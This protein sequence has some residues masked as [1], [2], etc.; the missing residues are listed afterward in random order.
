MVPTEPL[1]EK[2]IVQLLAPNE[3]RIASERDI[4]TLSNPQEINV[5]FAELSSTRY[6]TDY[7]GRRSEY[8][9]IY[10]ALKAAKKGINLVGLF[11][12]VRKMSLNEVIPGALTDM[13]KDF[14]SYRNS[15]IYFLDSNSFSPVYSY[16]KEHPV[17]P[18]SRG[19]YDLGIENRPKSK[20]IRYIPNWVEMLKFMLNP[21]EG[22]VQLNREVVPGFSGP[23]W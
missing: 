3:V 2:S 15:R 17:D 9:G 8:A 4:D 13:H 1:W 10:L 14:L 22:Q 16:G 6:G 18:H 19:E 5:L 23:I 20:E 11:G 7:A 12:R 21:N